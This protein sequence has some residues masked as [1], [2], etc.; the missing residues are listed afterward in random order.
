MFLG[1]AQAGRGWEQPQMAQQGFGQV[2]GNTG[3][4]RGQATPNSGWNQGNNANFGNGFAG[5]YQA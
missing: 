1:P 5:G 2:P 3:Y 4:G